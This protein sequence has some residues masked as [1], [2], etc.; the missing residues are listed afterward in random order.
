MDGRGGG[1]RTGTD[2]AHHHRID[3]LLSLP[4]AG[5]PP[6]TAS[7][8]RY[9]LVDRIRLDHA[10]SRV[11]PAGSDLQVCHSCSTAEIAGVLCNVPLVDRLRSPSALQFQ[12][13]EA[14]VTVSKKT[15]SQSAD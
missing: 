14:E 11:R 3:T 12:N 15:S 13:D 2:S 1:I 8:T 10:G 5:S 7:D 4:E 9:L 6:D